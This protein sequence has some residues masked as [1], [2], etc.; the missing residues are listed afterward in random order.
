MP[1]LTVRVAG[2]PLGKLIELMRRA[3]Y[4]GVTHG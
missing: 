3:R 4:V 1:Y 2:G